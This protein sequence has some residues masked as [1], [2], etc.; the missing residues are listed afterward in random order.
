M[1]PDLSINEI[2]DIIVDVA[3]FIHTEVGSGLLENVYRDVM[4]DLLRDQ[5]LTVETEVLIPCG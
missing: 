1:R 4:A 5:G 3:Y 2:T